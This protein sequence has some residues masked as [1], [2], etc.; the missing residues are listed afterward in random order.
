[1]VVDEVH[2][3]GYDDIVGSENEGLLFLYVALHNLELG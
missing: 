2:P 1:M 3:N